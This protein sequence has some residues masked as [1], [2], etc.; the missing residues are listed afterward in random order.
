[1]RWM[2]DGWRMDGWMDE[3]TVDGKERRYI[4]VDWHMVVWWFFNS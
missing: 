3:Y 2:E 4:D 1:M